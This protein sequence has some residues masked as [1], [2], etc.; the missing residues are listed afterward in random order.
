MKK[1][2]Q[3][4]IIRELERAAQVSPGTDRSHYKTTTEQERKDY[5]KWLSKQAPMTASFIV[6]VDY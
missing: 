3:Y 6:P 1:R 5:I 2:T 4:S